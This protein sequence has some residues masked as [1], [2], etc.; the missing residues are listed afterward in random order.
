MNNENAHIGSRLDALLC[1]EG[2]LNAVNETAQARIEAWQ[3]RVSDE[4]NRSQQNPV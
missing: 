2:V 3:S 4:A 1:D